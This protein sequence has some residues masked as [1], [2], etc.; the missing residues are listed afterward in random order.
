MT[1]SFPRLVREALRDNEGWTPAWR[2]PA[3]K[4]AYDV[5]SSAAAAMGWRPPIISPRSTASPTSRCW[6]R[7]GSAPAMPGATPR[8]SAPT[9]CCPA[10]AVLRAVDEAVGRAGAG[11]QLQLHGQP[12][13]RAEPVPLRSRSATPTARRGNAMRLHG[14]DAELLDA[15]QVRRLV[16]LLDFDNARFP[17]QGGLLQRRG[18]TARHDAVVWGYARGGG[19]ARRRHHPELRGDRASASSDGRVMGVETTRGYIGAGKVGLA[20]AG[21]TSRVA[22]HGR[23]AAADREPRA[24][25]VRVGG[26]QAADPERGDLRR[27]AFLHQPVGQGRPGVRRRHRRL[28]F[29]CPAR[30]P[31]DWSRT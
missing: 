24:A 8:S 4:P 22:A 31:A 1:Y 15:E 9:I 13:R 5:W 14:V 26:D 20:V 28:Q 2:D 12:A 17:I 19:P 10:T 30:Q 6:R 11:P 29:L 23:P 3:P 18:G 25:G 7:A 16:P 27:R 21:N